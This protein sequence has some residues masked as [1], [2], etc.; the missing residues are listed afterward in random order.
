MTRLEPDVVAF[1]RHPNDTRAVD[2]G[3]I[4]G[5]VWVIETRLSRCVS[6]VEYPCFTDPAVAPKAI[7]QIRQT[8]YP[9]FLHLL[10]QGMMPL[11]ALERVTTKGFSMP[12]LTINERVAEIDRSAQAFEEADA[13]VKLH[14]EEIA[15]ASAKCAVAIETRERFRE[16]H[17]RSTFIHAMLDRYLAGL[18]P[19][20]S[21]A[22]QDADP[23][24]P[25]AMPSPEDF[26]AHTNLDA[27]AEAPAPLSEPVSE[28]QLLPA[29]V[30]ESLAV[31][32]VELPDTTDVPIE[33]PAEG[34]APLLEEDP[35]P[36]LIPEEVP[37]EPS[38]AAEPPAT[39]EPELPAATEDEE[40]EEPEA[41]G[42]ISD[43]VFEY[44]AGH[45]NS[46]CR[47]VSEAT[48]MGL[49]R[50]SSAMAK[51]RSAN[52]VE[53]ISGTSP[54]AYRVPKPAAKPVPPVVPQPAAVPAESERDRQDRQ[55]IQQSR[56]QT[57]PA[58][59]APTKVKPITD[60]DEEAV[61]KALLARP[62]HRGSASI[63]SS[64]A[65]M[66]AYRTIEVLEHLQVQGRVI[67]PEEGEHQWRLA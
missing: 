53:W 7:H 51:L 41:V 6:R 11:A 9:A 1:I 60:R 20:A 48:G 45:P 61:L 46:T 65:G 8:D 25:E 58:T 22:S 2:R 13:A 50:V 33:L 57:P 56:Q 10:D 32:P 23:V 55:A 24:T 16:A 36:V 42:S 17:E 12:Q 4:A 35:A 5:V 21:P 14:E 52:R 15:V 49:S 43:R 63:L 59:P 37:V 44:V 18:D 62:N 54:A 3:R 19:E 27:P 38:V 39:E 26:P 29:E 67:A 47:T 40:T 30:D 31:T 28:A 64:K 34:G 66:S